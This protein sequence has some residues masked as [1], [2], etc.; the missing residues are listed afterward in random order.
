MEDQA[1]EPVPQLD[2]FTAIGGIDHRH[3]I[4]LHRQHDH[5][6]VQHLIVLDIVEQRGRHALARRSHEYSG[7]RHPLGRAARALGED[8]ER[9]PAFGHACAHQ[10]APLGPGGEH[11]ENH[12]ADHQREP[13]AIGHLGEVRGEIGTVDD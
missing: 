11:G 13:A 5:A 3:V 4:D 12:R 8:F 10:L 7:S 1:V 6:L 9:Q 2:H